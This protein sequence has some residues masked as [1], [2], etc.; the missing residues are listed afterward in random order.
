MSDRKVLNKYYPPDY[1]VS[2]IPR[3][4]Q[5]PTRQLSSRIMLPMSVQCLQCGEFIY[6]G[7]KFNARKEW[8]GDSYLSIKRFRFYFRCPSCLNEIT[9]ITDPQHAGYEVEMG[10]TRNVEPWKDRKEDEERQ[11]AE[12][13]QEDED[14]M[15][16]LENRS[17][18]GKREAEMAE[19]IEELR[20]RNGKGEKISMDELIELHVRQKERQE[21]Q[22]DD[23]QA[24]E[25]FNKRIQE[26]GQQQQQGR[27]PAAA[28]AAAPAG[29][30][31][32]EKLDF[33]LLDGDEV[34]DGE[35]RAA[36]L[37]ADGAREE[38]KERD[39]EKA[40]D[41]AQSAMGAAAAE[42]AEDDD[43]ARQRA[44]LS[45]GGLS[46]AALNRTEAA[47][48]A[49]EERKDMTALPPLHIVVKKRKT[50]MSDGGAKKR[51]AAPALVTAQ[52]LP[53][54]SAAPMPAVSAAALSSLIGGYS[55]DS[56]AD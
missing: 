17:K 55:D 43:F 23:R 39:A 12:R 11:R 37:R 34:A 1:D 6:R 19:V 9:F 26:R 16:R 31:T 45:A 40:S 4:R 22:E 35:A 2:L 49:G 32:L 44:E 24:K 52:S 21:Q 13:Q 38:R 42:E 47:A 20:E 53:P 41:G 54:P 14:V 10:A 36:G 30:M 3:L 46:F 50:E 7:K 25:A 51:K 48:K 8:T 28:A 18:D 56:D 15:R 29:V 27:R 5:A 33:E